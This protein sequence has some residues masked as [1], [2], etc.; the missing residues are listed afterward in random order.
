[1]AFTRAAWEAAGGFPEQ[2]YAGEDVAFSA[3]VLAAGLRGELVGGAVVD[4]R[5][6]P[7]WRANARMYVIYA[8]GDVRQGNSARHLIRAAT[9]LALP[10]LARSQVGRAAI[11]VWALGYSAVPIARARRRGNGPGVVCRIPLAIALKDLSQITG[12][13][14]GLADALRSAPQPNPN[15]ARKE[16]Q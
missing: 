13:A 12:A 4:W 2:L 5:P 15:R 7:T 11:A 6:R 9:W 1:M 10:F 14:L 8:R 3:A 16:T